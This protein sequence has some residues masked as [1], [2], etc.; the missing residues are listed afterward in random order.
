[1]WRDKNNR[2]WREIGTSG[3]GDPEDTSQQMEDVWKGTKTTERKGLDIMDWT[4][5][6]SDCKAGRDKKSKSIAERSRE[7]VEKTGTAELVVGTRL[8]GR[9][10]ASATT[11]SEQ[12]CGLV[13]SEM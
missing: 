10:R 2:W 3:Q 8:K 12:E 13:N 9:E 7:T 6:H 1:M 4:E 5:G 11:F